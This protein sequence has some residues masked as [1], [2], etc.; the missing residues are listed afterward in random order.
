[1]ISCFTFVGTRVG[2]ANFDF[3]N[4]TLELH[5]VKG[6]A[7]VQEQKKEKLETDFLPA[8]SRRTRL[9]F[10]IP[11][12]QNH[13]WAKMFDL[14]TIIISF[15]IFWLVFL[16]SKLP[17]FLC[18]THDKSI[19]SQII[20]L[21]AEFSNEKADSVNRK[22]F[23]WKIALRN[24]TQNFNFMLEMW[25]SGLCDYG[26]GWCF[27]INCFPSIDAWSPHKKLS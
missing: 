12:S 21:K 7:I 4:C 24:F 3:I 14:W 27:G 15:S 17:P 11:S 6:F 26:R 20:Y 19:Q 5:I 2:T 22:L 23:L 25:A 16:V 18:L 8:C 13:T 10:R 9:L 1:M